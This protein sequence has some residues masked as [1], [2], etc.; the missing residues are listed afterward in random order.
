[1][2]RPHK[3]QTFSTQ[4][5]SSV[6]EESNDSYIKRRRA[7]EL[8]KPPVPMREGETLLYVGGSGTKRSLMAGWYGT[9]LVW[10]Y[11]IAV[12]GAELFNADLM[13]LSTSWKLAF[14][15][16]AA[17]TS[18]FAASTTSIMMRYAVLTEDGQH[19]RLYPYGNPYGIGTGTAVT[20][21]I[22][23]LRETSNEKSA[24]TYHTEVLARINGSSACVVF[25]K[26]PQ[27]PLPAVPG[28]ALQWTERGVALQKGG[29]PKGAVVAGGSAGEATSLGLLTRQTKEELRRYSVLAYLL[30]PETK[31]VNAAVVAAGDW[32]LDAMKEQLR[33][34]VR[35]Q[36]EGRARELAL[37]RK[38]VDKDS[39]KEYW[40]NAVTWQAQ[41]DMPMVDGKGPW[42]HWP[43]LAALPVPST[44]AAPPI[45]QSLQ[46]IRK[47]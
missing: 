46:E 9:T 31:E 40:F 30:Q 7:L 42:E 17:L 23:M 11:L 43:G 45:I 20:V 12:S 29:L 19:V 13:L 22:S 47:Q 26:P 16:I 4:A 5:Q 6:V 3:L 27:V 32:E 38:A 18:K 1:M 21:P 10:G 15:G 39:G 36:M 14:A 28:S 24:K 41:W 35:S 8:E 2:I 33:P 34:V 44:R 37:W 25:D